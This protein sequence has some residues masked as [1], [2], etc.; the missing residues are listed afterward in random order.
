[1]AFRAAMDCDISSRGFSTRA[2]IINYRNEHE[3][4]IFVYLKSKAKD[5]RFDTYDSSI[6]DMLILTQES[7]QFSWRHLETV[8]FDQFLLIVSIC[9]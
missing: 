2:E 3:N 4:I 6:G 9:T 1:M 7:F 5:L 8:H